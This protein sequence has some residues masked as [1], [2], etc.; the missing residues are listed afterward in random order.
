MLYVSIFVELLRSRLVVED[1][2]NK[3]HLDITARPR[4]FPI[5]G[6]LIS[7]VLA[8]QVRKWEKKKSAAA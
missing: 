8:E 6:G 3:L 2:V 7:D 5:V 4:Y 1:T